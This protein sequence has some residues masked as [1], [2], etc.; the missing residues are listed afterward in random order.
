[1]RGF[2]RVYVFVEFERKVN[3]ELFIFPE[4]GRMMKLGMIFWTKHKK[5]LRNM[6]VWSWD[7]RKCMQTKHIYIRQEHLFVVN[8]RTSEE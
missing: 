6:T 8:S 7:I 1:M 4:R 5:F 2:C 3:E